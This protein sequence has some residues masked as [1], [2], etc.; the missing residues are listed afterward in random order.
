M[1][2]NNGNANARGFAERIDAAASDIGSLRDALAQLAGVDER[3]KQQLDR[4][5]RTEKQIML[6]LE[7]LQ[8]FSGQQSGSSTNNSNGGGGNDNGL[9]QQQW[10]ASLARLIFG[11]DSNIQ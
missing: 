3:L 4:M 2:D 11:D 9:N 8:G 10:Q 6:A 1:T 5:E 7:L